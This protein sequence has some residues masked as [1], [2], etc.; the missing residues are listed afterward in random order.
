ME[1][2]EGSEWRRLKDARGTDDEV[3]TARVDHIKGAR[4]TSVHLG[5]RGAESFDWAPRGFFR[6]ENLGRNV[7]TR[8]QRDLS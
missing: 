5:G 4:Q 8:G 1:A 3:M 2:A 7:K 6:L